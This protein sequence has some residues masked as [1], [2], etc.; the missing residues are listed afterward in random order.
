MNKKISISLLAVIAGL[1]AAFLSGAAQ[2]Q[3]NAS[4]VS[5]LASYLP[6]SDAIVM[7][8]VKRMLNE[9]M[10]AILAGDS[11]KLAQANAEIDKFKAKVGVDPRLFDRVAISM[12]YVYPTPHSTRVETVAIG[13]GSFDAKAVTAAV[14]N[15]ANGRFREEKYHGA[16]LRSSLSTIR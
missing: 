14:R 3:R 10:P 15:N 16:T 5:D 13:R 2:P 4:A 6:A 7:V 12:R 1:T 8:D 9:T 11:A